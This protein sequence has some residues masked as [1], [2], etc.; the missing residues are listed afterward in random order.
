MAE[1]DSFYY[2]RPTGDSFFLYDRTACRLTH[3]SPLLLRKIL[4]TTPLL[5][6]QI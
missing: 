6:T 2:E 1:R 5:V 3:R 4:S